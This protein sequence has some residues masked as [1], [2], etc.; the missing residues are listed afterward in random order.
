MP[1]SLLRAIASAI[2]PYGPW[3][4]YA[5]SCAGVSSSNPVAMTP[6]WTITTSSPNCAPSIRSVS[7]KASSACF[8]A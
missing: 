2:G 8:D 3:P 4:E 1:A 6:G 7:E 5:R